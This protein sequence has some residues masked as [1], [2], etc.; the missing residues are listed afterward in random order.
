MVEDTRRKQKTSEEVQ[1]RKYEMEKMKLFG[2]LK[3]REIINNRKTLGIR[4]FNNE[5]I[6][7]ISKIQK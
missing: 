7:K 4:K 2:K 5:G 3:K 1:P 6:K